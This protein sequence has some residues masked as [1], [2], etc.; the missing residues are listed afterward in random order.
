MT[1]KEQDTNVPR[2]T[3]EKAAACTGMDPMQALKSLPTV[4]ALRHI[5]DYF[6]GLSNDMLR[7]AD[8]DGAQAMFK[9]AGDCN[10]QRKTIEEK[11]VKP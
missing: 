2:G 6:N 3:P 7:S 5:A 9:L 4:E 11:G 10:S 8:Y 1:D